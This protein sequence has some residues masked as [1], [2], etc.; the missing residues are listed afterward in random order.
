MNQFHA[1]AV[2]IIVGNGPPAPFTCTGP[3]CSPEQIDLTPWQKLLLSD[4]ADPMPIQY[5]LTSLDSLL[6]T[7]QFPGDIDIEKKQANL[8]KFLEQDYCGSIP[9]CAPPN[10]RGYWTRQPNVTTLR[11][12]LFVFR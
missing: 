11:F 6:T 1:N 3:P 10:P 5:S 9:N 7:S 12:C 4:E 8:Q 2:E